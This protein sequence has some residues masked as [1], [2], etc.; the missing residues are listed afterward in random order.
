MGRV[1]SPRA[2]VVRLVAAAALVSLVIGALAFYVSNRLAEQDTIE[3]GLRI[4]GT[5]ASEITPR[6]SERLFAGEANAVADLDT[7]V[8]TVMSHNGVRRIKVF[9][10]SGRVLYSDEHRLI[11]QSF[12]LAEIEQAAF[13]APAASAQ[14]SSPNGA[15]NEFEA[16]P[17]LLIEV[18][19]PLVGWQQRRA[20]LE[21]YLDY[22]IVGQRGAQLWHAFVLLLTASL[23][24][25]TLLVIP[26]AFQLLRRIAEGNRQRQELLQRAVA[27]SDAE[28]RR[29]AGSL[30]DG[31]VQE[32]VGSTLALGAT[33]AEL[34]QS[35][36]ADA[37]AAVSG[38]ASASRRTVGTLRTLLV[39]LYP[40]SLDE[41]A[42]GAALEDL[43]G[44]LR[45]RGL[46]T[47]V[48]LQDPALAPS[49]RRLI[50]RVTQECLRNVS[51]HSG[52]TAV[53]VSLRPD[54]AGWRLRITDNGHGFDV[55]KTLAT[56]TPGHYGLRVM[57]DVA[58]EGGLGLRVAS[59][60]DGTAWELWKGGP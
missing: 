7:A 36:Q 32:L 29:I 2:V 57:K 38:A 3:E 51:Q 31:P 5:L 9:D 39:D 20:M 16:V 27:A 14:I 15:E 37:A 6:L 8:L 42:L 1:P 22:A 33:A 24:L 23:A 25:M 49:E 26:V 19:Q 48:D 12:A 60:P 10:D 28:R 45:A 30:H 18:R 44:P 55:A 17:G 13:N 53:G 11:G 40:A 58:A 52:A 46:A 59:G 41:I 34:L 35:G 47:S 43:L 21:V 50:H 54:V 4:T 56:P